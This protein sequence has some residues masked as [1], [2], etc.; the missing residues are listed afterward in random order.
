[1]QCGKASLFLFLFLSTLRSSITLDCVGHN[2][3][4]QANKEK[5]NLLTGTFCPVGVVLDEVLTG[6]DNLTPVDGFGE[7]QV[8]IL[9]DAYG[10]SR[11][12]REFLQTDLYRQYIIYYV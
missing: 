8:W 9:L 7:A 3:T 12:P 4:H 2:H 5:S 1:M 6:D 10:S 11:Y